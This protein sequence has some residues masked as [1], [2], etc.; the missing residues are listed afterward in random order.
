MFV[1]REEQMDAFSQAEI[2]K[3][4][5]RMVLHLQ[6]VFPDQTKN[7]PNPDLL[8]MIQLGI[9]K[10]TEYNITT[11]GDVRRYL[12]CSILYGWDFDTKPETYWAG[13]ILRD[14]DLDGETKMDMIEQHEAEQQ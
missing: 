6:S 13:E 7:T 14:D 5:N 12:E 9:E 11:E 4:E 3:F 1:I 8:N 2:E 10:S